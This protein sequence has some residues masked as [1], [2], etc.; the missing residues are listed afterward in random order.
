MNIS[1]QKNK[2]LRPHYPLISAIM[3]RLLV[4]QISA[5]LSEVNTAMTI[6][7]GEAYLSPF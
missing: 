5:L 4:I 6:S 3:P 1:D 7:N 2:S